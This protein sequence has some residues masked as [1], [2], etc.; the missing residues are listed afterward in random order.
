MDFLKQY[1]I[2]QEYQSGPVDLTENLDEYLK[3]D[4]LR[5]EI[6]GESPE[7]TSDVG[8]T[9]TIVNVSST[10]GFP[11]RYGLFKINDEILTY[12]GITTNSLLDVFVV[13]VVLQIIIKISMMKN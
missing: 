13:L 3:L 8:N 10:K 5:P 2:S 12:T 6:T 1:Y 4:N 11:D 9:S 7:L